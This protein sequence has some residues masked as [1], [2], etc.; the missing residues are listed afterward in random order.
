MEAR[1]LEAYLTRIHQPDLAE[2]ARVLAD[3]LQARSIFRITPKVEV[4]QGIRTETFKVGTLTKEDMRSRF[5]AMNLNRTSYTQD[6]IGQ[7]TLSVVERSVT[8]VFLTGR[9]LGLTTRA[10]YREFLRAGQTKGYEICDAEVALYLRL[11]DSKQPLNATY[12]VAMEPITDRYGHPPVFGL[13]H[14]SHGM[15]LRAAWTYPDSLWD[16]GSRLAF[17]LPASEPQKP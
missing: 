2:Q 3:T 9:D 16:P 8:V 17:S 1:E 14:N 4:P 10:P 15:W 6:L 11:H 5:E 13:E 12:W 7:I